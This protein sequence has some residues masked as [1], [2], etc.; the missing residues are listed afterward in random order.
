MKTIT[1]KKQKE[2]LRQKTTKKKRKYI[3]VKREESESEPNYEHE[4]SKEEEKPDIKILK[5]P[6]KTKAAEQKKYKDKKDEKNIW[7]SQQKLDK[8]CSEK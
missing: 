6:W 8:R 1:E 4:E 2:S 7:I 3:E 5:K